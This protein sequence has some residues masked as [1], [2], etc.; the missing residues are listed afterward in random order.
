MRTPLH[1]GGTLRLQPRPQ[2]LPPAADTAVPTAT[3]AHLL[4]RRIG[5][6]PRY[7][8][9]GFSDPGVKGVQVGQNPGHAGAAEQ[10]PLLIS[11]ARP[12][13]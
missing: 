11:Q 10:R 8:S 4:R 2:T 12:L 5:Q 7:L 13:I 3:A 1:P 6:L 9:Q